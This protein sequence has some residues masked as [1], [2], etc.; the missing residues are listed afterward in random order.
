MNGEELEQLWLRVCSKLKSY[1]EVDKNQVE[2]LFSRLHPQ[3]ATKEGYI[4]ITA[5]NEFIKTWIEKFYTEWIEKALEELYKVKFTVFLEVF[6]LDSK[7]QSNNNAIPNIPEAFFDPNNK[8]PEAHNTNE[9]SKAENNK[10]QQKNIETENN[11]LNLS[12]ID[13]N[14]ANNLSAFTFENFVIGNSNRMAYQ[15]ALSVAEAPGKPHLNPLFIYGKSGL[16]KTHLLRAIQN[17][18]S[19]TIK[20]MN[21]IYAD[22][23]D[24]YNDYSDAAVEKNKNKD[25]FRTF[26]EKYEQ[27]DVLLIDDVQQL[28]GKRA[29]LDIVFQI[30]NKLTSK[31]KQVVLSADRAP[32]NIDIDDRYKSRFNSGGTMDIQSP[33]LET[34]LGIIK[35]HI[36]EYQESESSTNLNIPSE[37]Q[38]YIAE[39]SGSNIRELKSAVTKVIYQLTFTPNKTVTLRDVKQLLENHFSSGPTKKLTVA[40]IQ[41]EVENFFKVSHSELIGKKRSREITHARQVA[42]F[43]CRELLE[44]P[45]EDVGKHFNRDHSTAMYAVTTIETK[46]KENEVLQ[47]EI[48]TIKQ[49]IKEI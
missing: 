18:I 28:Q 29:T 2:A 45:Y 48:E 23:S 24:L 30:F 16:G 17:Y 27:A 47:E 39:A 26:K 7:Q 6:P 10:N 49:I 11:K 25:S 36:K 44:I 8:T 15:M 33:E 42:I 35:S 46:M 21:T 41:K 9:E 19:K 12:L 22:A 40:D 20:G 1:P 3:A 43:L 38:S 13:Q 5:D 31:G 37:I 4:I 14:K 32:K 34:K